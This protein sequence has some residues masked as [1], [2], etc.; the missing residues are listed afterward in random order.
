M[1]WDAQAKIDLKRFGA[2]VAIAG[3]YSK[4]SFSNY[5]DALGLDLNN[6]YSAWNTYNNSPVRESGSIFANIGWNAT[7]SFMLGLEWDNNL[8]SYAV[9]PG[10][11]FHSNSF[12]MIGMYSF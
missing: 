4:V 6:T 10:A 7:K 5:N 1:Q 8:T 9:D 12:Y 2:P 3:G 11:S